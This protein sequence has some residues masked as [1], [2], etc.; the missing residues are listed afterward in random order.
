MS[1]IFFFLWMH[2]LTSN[3]DI[4]F[5]SIFNH[6]ILSPQMRNKVYLSNNNMLLRLTSRLFIWNGKRWKLE[7]DKY[8]GAYP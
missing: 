5:V 3:T 1:Q 8:L 7:Q 6:Y 2:N 4:I